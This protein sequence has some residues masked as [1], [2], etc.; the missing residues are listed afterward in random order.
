MKQAEAYI[1]HDDGLEF[2]QPLPGNRSKE[3]CIQK[4]TLELIHSRERN[5]IIADSI[6]LQT[7]E[8][9]SPV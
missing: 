1:P 2:Q 6:Q 3:K 9:A 5:A 8:E 4:S 7:H